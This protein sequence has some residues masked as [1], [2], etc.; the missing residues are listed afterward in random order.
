MRF[1]SRVEPPFS[2]KKD[3]NAVVAIR[4]QSVSDPPAP[5]AW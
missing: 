3:R 4:I 1:A 5:L 2:G